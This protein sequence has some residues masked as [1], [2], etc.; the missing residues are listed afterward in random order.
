M[1]TTDRSRV[2][3]RLDGIVQSANE[4]GVRLQGTPDWVNYS[5]YADPPIA[6]PRRGASV[7]LGLDAD[8][9]IRGLEVLDDAAASGDTDRSREIRR[10]V[11][12][13]VAGQL[14]SAAIQSHED[15]RL[16]H[17]DQVAD[18]VLRW[19]EKGD[20]ATD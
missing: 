9:Y 4:R 12:A 11:A 1:T 3:E 14:L 13:K 19:L 15:A 10:Q 6:S 16:D 5:K 20:A 18:R 7:R 17:F 8:G 2:V